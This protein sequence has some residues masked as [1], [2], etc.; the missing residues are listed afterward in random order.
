MVQGACLAAGFRP[1]VVQEALELSTAVTLVAA[2]IGVTLVPAPAGALRLEGVVYRPLLPPVP[3][4]QLVALRR[5]DATPPAALRFL[6]VAREV[7]AARRGSADPASGPTV[8]AGSPRPERRPATAGAKG[9]HRP[10][11]RAKRPRPPA[12]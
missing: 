6:E 7:L 12:R 4:T 3:T 1:S 10:V 11:P 2:G 8:P 5:P 9:D